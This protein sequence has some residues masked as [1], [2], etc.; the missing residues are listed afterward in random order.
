M[1]HWVLA[2]ESLTLTL[3]PPLYFFSFLYYT[4]ILSITF[5]LAMIFFALKQHYFVS[6]LFGLG[7]VLMRQ[8]NVVW[9]GIVFCHIAITHIASHR[10]K[11]VPESLRS[12]DLL[13]SAVGLVTDLVRRPRSFL[14]DF[15]FVVQNLWSFILVLTAFAAFVF[16]NGSIVVGDKSAHEANLHLAQVRGSLRDILLSS[17]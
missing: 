2:L 6:S 10:Q 14:V 9:V 12:E 13:K 5:V 11:K 17:Y 4:D 3:I 16:A 7:S 15:K 1:F 8:T